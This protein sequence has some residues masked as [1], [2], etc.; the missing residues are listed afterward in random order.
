MLS[1][2]Y[3]L[4]LI[5]VLPKYPQKMHRYAVFRKMEKEF[6]VEGLDIP[7]KFEQTVQNI[8]NSHCEGYAEFEKIRTRSGAKPYFKSKEKHSG[9]WSLHPDYVPLEP[10]SLDDF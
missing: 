5:D 4:K 7:N 3:L 8:Y 9:Y 10:L 6:C 2:D 1:K